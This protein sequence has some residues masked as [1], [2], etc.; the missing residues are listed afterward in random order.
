MNKV[1]VPTQ[2]EIL[3][4]EDEISLLQSYFC[5]PGEFDVKKMNGIKGNGE[6][7]IKLTNEVKLSKAPS[8]IIEMQLSLSYKGGCCFLTSNP[9]HISFNQLKGNANKKQLE[10]FKELVLA[11]KQLLLQN[12]EFSL[13]S[14]ITWISDEIEKLG[15]STLVNDIPEGD[16]ISNPNKEL[17][18]Y[19][20]L[21]K[22]DHIRSTTRYY[23]FFKEAANQFQ[24]NIKLIRCKKLIY[25][26]VCGSDVSLKE[27]IKGHRT[28]LVDVDSNGKPCK[29]RMLQIQQNK[30]IDNDIVQE[31]DLVTAGFHLIEIDDV[32]ELEKQLESYS[33]SRTET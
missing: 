17:C 5:K 27:Y 22:L 18:L 8:I 32:I 20:C 11:H 9:L 14:F 4:E 33:F 3:I 29:E 25:I 23:K 15:E 26:L 2:D 16:L 31:Y 19:G 10:H 6:Y 13:F 21:M 30:I 7:I 1:S 24:V 28:S 12:E